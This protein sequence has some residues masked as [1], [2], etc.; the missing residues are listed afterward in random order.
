M[1][2]IWEMTNQMLWKISGYWGESRETQKRKKRAPKK[3]QK[4]KKN[5]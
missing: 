4:S 1:V 3:N 5:K 2:E